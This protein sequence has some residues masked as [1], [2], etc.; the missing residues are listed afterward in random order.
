MRDSIW[1]MEGF[2]GLAYDF[3]SVVTL[4][5]WYAKCQKVVQCFK[6]GMWLKKWFKDLWEFQ[7]LMS[8]IQVK[9][10]CKNLFNFTLNKTL[11]YQ[12]N[13]V[14]WENLRPSHKLPRWVENF[15]VESQTSPLSQK[16]PRWVKNVPVE[17]KTSPL[18][19]K[20]PRWVTNFPVESQTFLLSV[21]FFIWVLK[22]DFESQTALSWVAAI[23][24]KS[25]WLKISFCLRHLCFS[26]K[27]LCNFF[28][29]AHSAAGSRTIFAVAAK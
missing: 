11:F 24:N 25:D 21:K 16:R 27:Y 22:I 5:K 26:K 28:G 8:D 4:K 29:V 12:Q 18:S 2:I 6:S 15:P 14:D 13:C 20:L 23:F 7:H 9:D 19:H 10:P 17:S 1:V 3:L